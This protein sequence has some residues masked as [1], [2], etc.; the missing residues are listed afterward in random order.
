M[1]VLPGDF[2][3]QL[4]SLRESHG[5]SVGALAQRVGVSKVTIWKW[6]KG[7]T[8]PR[9]R[10]V[11]PLAMAL[12]VAPI[13]LHLP[14]DIEELPSFP[15]ELSVVDRSALTEQPEI[16]AAN[17]GEALA[18][19]VARAKRMISE[20]SGVGPRNITISIEY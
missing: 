8:K 13:D 12:D 2:S 10:M 3:Q 11:I 5:L 16:D 6:E 17:D 15:T 14:V 20:A 18:D 1:A 4:R 19:V 9:T 7:E